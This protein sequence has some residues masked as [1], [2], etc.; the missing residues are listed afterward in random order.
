MDFRVI[1]QALPEMVTQLLGFLIV[2]VILKKF[3][4]GPILAAIDARRQKIGEEFQ[5]IE[6]KK[7]EL[8]D[9]EKEYKRRI[10]RIE[11]EARQKIQEAAE[12]GKTLAKE[13]Q[14]QAIA[15]ARRMVERAK[16]EIA[17]DIAQARLLLRDEIVG[18][19]GL[20]TEKIIKH[21]L[22]AKEHERLVDQ[23]IKEIEKV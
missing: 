5:G 17:H 2:F 7:R 14:D 16:A 6:K 3:A 9:L 13:V 4:F 18:L 12:I 20:M 15:D 19:S 8:E 23:F 10:D 22:D 21:K 1:Q 11:E